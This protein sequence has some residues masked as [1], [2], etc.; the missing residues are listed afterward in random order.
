VADALTR[1]TVRPGPFGLGCAPLGNLL[2]AIGDDEAAAVLDAAWEAGVRWYDTAP[3]YGLG[4]SERRLGAFL[5]TKPRHE[6]TVSTKVGRLLVPNPDGASGRDPEGFDVPADLRREWDFSAA[7]VRASLDSSL[8]RL[9]LDAV[10]VAL[11]HDPTEHADAA[12]AEA[13][14]A[15]AEL[16]AA[17]VIRA[18]GVGTRDT[19]VL[20]RFVE[21][22]A[23]DTVMLAG[24]FTLLDQ[25]ALDD[26]LPVCL[27]RGVSVLN[28]GVFNSGVLAT[29]E[30]ADDSTF[31]YSDAPSGIMRR[32]RQLAQL[33]RDFGTT[34]P[35]AALAYARSHPAIETVVVGAAHASQVR[36]NVGL[37][38]SPPVPAL[39][40][41]LVAEG[42]LPPSPALALA[43]IED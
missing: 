36:E 12:V 6:Y 33:C 4:L 35:A 38:T 34:L 37:V 30:P 32:A 40:E 16:R 28:A 13:Y 22:T 26:L 1:R 9:G 7:G 29:P 21:E 42:L 5:R 8:E 11:I 43:R 2:G 41:A 15:L 23:I 10:D 3:H 39:W 19:A 17:G 25:S 20:T 27:R 18:V 31:E 14:P 24:R